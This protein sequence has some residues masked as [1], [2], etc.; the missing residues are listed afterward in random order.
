MIVIVIAAIGRIGGIH[1]TEFWKHVGFPCFLYRPT[2]APT[3]AE[4]ERQSQ[5]KRPQGL[6]TRTSP[7]CEAKTRRM[8]QLS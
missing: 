1:A 5:D 4:I 8:E 3:D 7:P 2:H 6:D